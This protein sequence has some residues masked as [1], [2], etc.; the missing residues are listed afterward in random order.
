MKSIHMFSLL[1]RTCSNIS[2]TSSLRVD[3]LRF[4]NDVNKK[5][6]EYHVLL[7]QSNIHSLVLLP[8][9]SLQYYHPSKISSPPL[10]KVQVNLLY[11]S[12]CCVLI[13]KL[14]FLS[15]SRCSMLICSRYNQGV[16]SLHNFQ[17]Q[18]LVNSSIQIWS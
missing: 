10:G 5:S 12:K 8:N 3:V 2:F 9:Q 18:M 11:I 4:D 17:F 7:I 14:Q 1:S 6:F 16:Y 13:V 15:K